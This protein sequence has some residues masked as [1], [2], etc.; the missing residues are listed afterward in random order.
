[1][2]KGFDE[3]K[4]LQEKK[5]VLIML[6]DGKLDLG[7]PEKDAAALERLKRLLP[8]V[9]KANV[10][11]H[12][13]AFTSESDSA[14]LES[15]A[16]ETGGFFRFAR[17]DKDVHVMFAAIFERIKSP[18][19][20]PLEGETFTIDSQIREATVLV[21]KKPRTSLSL[22]DPSNKQYTK[23]RHASTIEWFESSV[24][25]MITIQE[26]SAGTWKIKLSES[27][28]NKVYILTHLNLK[29]SFDKSFVTKGERI[30]VEVWLEKQ[31]GVVTEEDVLARTTFS[32]EVTGPD[33]RVVKL[34]FASGSTP[35]VIRHADGKY[36]AMLSTTVVGDH[37]MRLLAQG[38]TF[39]REK[40]FP[41]KA[42]DPTAAPSAE[43]PPMPR[44]AP[45]PDPAQNAISWTV[46]LIKFLF[47]NLVMISLTAA[48]YFIRKKMSGR[49]K[50]NDN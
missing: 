18:D 24:F 8:E 17:E 2:Q 23:A 48:A 49:G 46:V 9:A 31:G 12:T 43:R 27:E 29:T 11:I 13:M 10:N 15:M 16:R 34:D 44:H 36:S 45:S 50:R 14:L 37:T 30:P 6:S 38:K 41:F 25:D 47:V 7:S 19:T 22:L 1:V 40:T 26:P 39:K 32:A 35:T 21:S 42:V 4:P 20:V 28:G 5:K 33:G 3:L